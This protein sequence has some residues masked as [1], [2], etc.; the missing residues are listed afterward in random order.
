MNAAADP[1]TFFH[2]KQWRRLEIGLLVAILLLATF[3]RFWQL[4][5]M[6]PGFYHDEAY[7]GLDALSLVQGKM[8]PQFY[9]GWEL[10]AQDA[11]AGNPPDPTRFPLFFEG[12][13]GREPVHIYLMALSLKLFG[14]TPFAVRA[15]PALAGVLAVLT[16]FLA[17]KVVLRPEKI[18]DQRVKIEENR[19]MQSLI[20]NLSPLF[21]AFTLAILFPAIHFSRFGLR[22]ML[23][24]PVETLAVVCFWQGITARR[25]GRVPPWLWLGL[26][27]FLLGF[28]L[29][30]YAAA[31]LFPLLFVAVGLIWWWR[32]KTAVLMQWRG[33]LLRA[34][35]AGITAVPILLFFA[36]YPYFFIFRIGYVANKGLGAVAG[37][38][39]LTWLLN[40]GR[41]VRGFFWQGETHLRHNLPGRP[42]LDSIQAILFLLGLFCSAQL[43]LRS[44]FLKITGRRLDQ[45]SRLVQSKKPLRNTQYAIRLIFLLLW[46]AVMLLPSVMSGD[47]P[48]FGRLTGAAPVVAIFVGM[49][50]AWLG[51]RLAVI[52]ERLAVNGERWSVHDGRVLGW[53]GLG[54]LLGMSL[55]VTGRDY[56]G[57]YA[58]HPQL[59]ADFYLPDWELGQLAAAQ[60]PDTQL[61][62]T[63]TQEEMATIYFA[64]ADPARMRSYS[65]AAGAIPAGV[66]G[67]PSL[68]FVRPEDETSLHNLQTY[69]PD[70]LTQPQ[71]N[72]FIPFALPAAAPRTP[73]LTPVDVAWAEQIRLV[74]WSLTPDEGQLPITLAWQALTP[75]EI[76]YTV[77]IHLLG[78]EASPIAQADR[79]PGGYPTSDWQP[80]EIVVDTFVVDLPP[81]LPP[82]TYALH[83]GMYDLTTLERLGTA[84]L[85]DIELPNE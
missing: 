42:Y 51:Y 20:F 8:F 25:K 45:S 76:D 55:F 53:M 71:Q 60:P 79:P 30:V 22:A 68:Y 12:N 13:Y 35:V 14:A 26:A 3:L 69:F 38:P 48:H 31:R 40:V 10:Y 23:F 43:I 2:S 56:F 17:A 65:G 18:G 74:G 62:L 36:R 5:Q 54:L 7:N 64:L 58:S 73:G 80:G 49:G 85:T 81:D 24:V 21:A 32:D 6:P 9:E 15:V 78:T 44:D 52:G 61:Y 33:L 28:G 63:P 67:Q 57:R 59:A 75:I 66:A 50:G 77:F 82:G 34:G 47:A 46:L 39:W 16:T 83:T 11:H 84:V 72:G 19:V 29:Y 41:V 27:G 70:G 1:D 37:K 4:A